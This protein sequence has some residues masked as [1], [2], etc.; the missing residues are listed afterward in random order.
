MWKYRMWNAA[1]F[2][3]CDIFKAQDV[4]FKNCI[5]AQGIISQSMTHG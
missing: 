3:A 2:E 1:F 5:E 4:I